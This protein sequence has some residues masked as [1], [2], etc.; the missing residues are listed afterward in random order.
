MSTTS[1]R[2]KAAAALLGFLVGGAT[3]FLL[4]ETVGAFLTFV[5]DRSLD[6][7]GTGALLAAFIAVPILC[8][9]VGA[10]IGA[11]LAGRPPFQ[12]KG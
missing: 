7:D 3:G 10:A 5:L 2:G 11:H 6:V 9:L 1:L 4:T 8:A 12:N